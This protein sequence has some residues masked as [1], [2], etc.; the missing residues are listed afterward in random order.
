MD[1][2]KMQRMLAEQS[3]NK[4]CSICGTPFTPYNSRQQ[5]C[6]APDCQK[7]HHAEY[8]KT[9]AARLKEKDIEAWRKYHREAQAKSRAKKRER[10]KRDKE[11]KRLQKKWEK[12]AEFDEM[13]RTDGLNYGERQKKKTLDMIP[14]ID[15]NIGGEKE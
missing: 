1:L 13:V 4:F 7:A 9:R 10:I 5:T 14:K 6:G 2:M 11:L 12:Q 15:V 8:M 3:G